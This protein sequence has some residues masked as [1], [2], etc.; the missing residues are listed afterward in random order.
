M[1]TKRKRGE[2]WHYT[3][4]RSILPKPI[5]LSF[6]SE[7]DGDAYVAK[8]ER[9]LDRGIIPDEFQQPEKKSAALAGLVRDYL[10][11]VSVSPQD[12][13]ILGR[14]DPGRLELFQLDV[15]WAMG[16]VAAL[17][18]RQVAPVTIRHHVGALARCLDHATRQGLMDSNPLRQLPRG[19]STYRDKA[20]EDMERDRRLTEDEEAAI[21]RVLGGWKPPDK[22]RSIELEHREAHRLLFTLALETA[23]R[24]SEMYT[25]TPD[26]VDIQRR[27]IF[28]ERTKNGDKRQVPLSTVAV[29]ALEGWESGGDYLLPFFD[30]NRQRTTSRLSRIWSRIFDHAGCPDVRFHDCRH[31][32]TS[33]FFERTTLTDL[34]IARITGH[35]DPR[36]LMRYANL[37]GSD[38]AQHLP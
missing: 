18:E 30:G 4:R 5:Y 32:S 14:F 15:R 27:T 11:E 34:Q 8:L 6:P 7:N 37:R 33:R 25:L 26:Q 1:A 3:V 23:M 13:Q 16:W 19:Y 20:R 10:R 17:K 29:R 36:M 21:W 22:Q 2:T 9:L 38:L 12:Q 28:L 24:M 31:E 35:R